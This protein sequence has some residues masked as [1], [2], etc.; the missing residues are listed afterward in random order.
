MKFTVDE[1]LAQLPLPATGKWKD[2]VRDLEPH[3]TGKVSLVFFAPGKTD[4]QTFHDED[5]YYFVARGSGE[6]VIG[7]KTDLAEAK[8]DETKRF[9]AE[10]GDVFFVEAGVH[11]RFENFTEDFATWAVF[12]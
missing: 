9:T 7:G 6:L 2:G 11:H 1:C 3:R 8:A 5:E 12:F 10:A 4:Y